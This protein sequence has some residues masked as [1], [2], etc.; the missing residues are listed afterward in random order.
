MST[1]NP[2]GGDGERKA[3]TDTQVGGRVGPGGVSGLVVTFE[4]QVTQ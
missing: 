3:I 2:A 4:R 1:W